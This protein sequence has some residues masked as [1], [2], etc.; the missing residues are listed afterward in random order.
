MDQL[1]L[2]IIVLL[3]VIHVIIHLLNFVMILLIILNIMKI[4]IIIV[5]PILIQMEFQQIHW[6]MIYL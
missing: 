2:L 1:P 6:F 3:N 4:M 5:L